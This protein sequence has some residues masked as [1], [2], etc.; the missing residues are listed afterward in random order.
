MRARYH[1]GFERYSSPSQVA[2]ATMISMRTFRG[3]CVSY[4]GIQ[5]DLLQEAVASSCGV[6]IGHRIRCIAESV[7]QSSADVEPLIVSC[8]VPCSSLCPLFLASYRC[9]ICCGRVRSI[10]K[11]IPGACFSISPTLHF[12]FILFVA[13]LLTRLTHLTS[14]SIAMISND[15]Q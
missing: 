9:F 2:M 8:W 5:L 15:F 1:S 14:G 3:G 11:S 6:S 13:T 4:G 12:F 7:A 10:I